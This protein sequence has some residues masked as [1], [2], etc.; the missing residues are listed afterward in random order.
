VT[1]HFN[2]KACVWRTFNSSF[3]NNATALNRSKDRASLPGRTTTQQSG[4]D[5][6]P[7]VRGEDVTSFADRI[8]SSAPHCVQQLCEEHDFACDVEGRSRKIDWEESEVEAHFKTLPRPS[9]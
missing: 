5:W 4:V 8:A 6:S 7:E 2:S 1:Y 3:L 9:V